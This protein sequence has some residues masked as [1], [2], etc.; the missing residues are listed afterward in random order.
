RLPWLLGPAALLAASLAVAPVYPTP[1]SA[2][3]SRR[4][5]S[6]LKEVRPILAQHCLGCHG[7]DEAARKGKLRL[8][9]KDHALAPRHGKHVIAPS[10]LA[11]SLLW[12]RISHDG[13]ERMPPGGKE[14]ALSEK[15]ITTL[16]T[17]I[18]QGAKWED[19]WS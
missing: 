8:D 10:D 16:K 12:E 5:V 7:P 13:T 2:V 18:E 11:R 19:H 4:P 15:Q 6:Y 14:Q 17:W 3:K 1:G 9:L